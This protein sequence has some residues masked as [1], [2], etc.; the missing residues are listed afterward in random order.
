MDKKISL[1]F[2]GQGAQIPGMGS[3]LYQ[4]YPEAK[5]I[6]DAADQ[7]SPTNK[8]TDLCFFSPAEKL[9]DCANCQPAI[10]TMSIACY[11]ALQAI[12]PFQPYAAAGLSLGEYGA[13]T[14]ANALSFKDTFHLVSTRGMLMDQCCHENA[15]RMAAILGQSEEEVRKL[16][17]E[18]DIDIANLNC[19]GQIIISGK[20]ENLARLEA[21]LTPESPHVVFLE[22]AG[23]YHSHLMQPAANKFQTEIQHY[24]IQKPTC[25]LAQNRCG[26]FVS[27]PT[28]I[29]KNL[30]QQISNSVLWEKC[31]RQLMAESDILIEFGPGKILTGMC[32]RMNR[33]FPVFSIHSAQSLE[34]TVKEL[35]S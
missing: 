22:V 32:R 21:S 7:L 33:K 2:A 9:T 8:M 30:V 10:F 28:Q 29:K 15:G 34:E 20:A 25:K 14:A 1:M 26:Q 12:F 13:L 35:K 4:K 23:A 19:P 31:L 27:D 11:T 18:F 5:K 6:F 16:C 17:T 24:T 3:D